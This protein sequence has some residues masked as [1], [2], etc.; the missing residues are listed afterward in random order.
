MS[1]QKDLVNAFSST[2]LKE[3]LEEEPIEELTNEDIEL[4]RMGF[5]IILA[6]KYKELYEKD[7][8]LHQ[9][10]P[11]NDFFDWYLDCC[12]EEMID[13]LK[14]HSDSFR[15]KQTEKLLTYKTSQLG[16][17]PESGTI[18]EYIEKNAELIREKNELSNMILSLQE[19]RD[20]WEDLAELAKRLIEIFVEQKIKAKLTK[21]EIKLVK[22]ISG[23]D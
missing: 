21:E 9:E 20:Y 4:A 8:V 17:K 15:E 14:E 22:E 23:N 16:K 11:T 5:Q 18:A 12:N 19:K 10:Y 1:K 7:S 2:P 13:R 3:A 6:D